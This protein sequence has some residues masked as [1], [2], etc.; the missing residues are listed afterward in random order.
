MQRKGQGSRR[1]HFLLLR[2]LTRTKW[3]KV[4]SISYILNL[5]LAHWSECTGGYKTFTKTW[6]VWS[7][8][9]CSLNADQTMLTNGERQIFLHVSASESDK[10]CMQNN[11]F[12]RILL[13]IQTDVIWELYL[14]IQPCTL[15]TR[16]EQINYYYN[17]T[18]NFLTLCVYVQK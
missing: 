17:F 16:R 6:R 10:I 7:L 4:W 12:I 8:C 14:K 3:L 1:E 9:C 2:H 11:C 18:I 15:K 5:L 13:A